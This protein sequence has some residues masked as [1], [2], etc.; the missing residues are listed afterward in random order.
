M[1]QSLEAFL[2]DP[3][4]PM[5]PSDLELDCWELGEL[6]DARAAQIEAHLETCL[7]CQARVKERRA[8]DRRFVQLQGQRRRR[9]YT[10]VIVA[11]AAIAAVLSLIWF[12]PVGPAL[13]LR[14]ARGGLAEVMGGHGTNAKPL[15]FA[16]SSRVEL[17]VAPQ[18]G[19]A[20]SISLEILGPDNKTR[21]A[22]GNV[23]MKRMG[24]GWLVVSE[25]RDL[26]GRTK[27]AF[28]VRV[29]AWSAQW[30]RAGPPLEF[31]VDYLGELSDAE[32]DSGPHKTNAE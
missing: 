11:A 31:T 12:R 21:P 30:G 20:A 17:L 14:E 1:E 8:V 7:Y 2:A 5:H 16:A 13:E 25:G 4:E 24:D 18:S 26:F 27:G 23:E 32:G 9:W 15:R 28:R 29:Q 22:Q 6:D 10:R 3:S 19:S